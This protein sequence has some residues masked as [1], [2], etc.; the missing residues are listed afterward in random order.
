MRYAYNIGWKFEIIV[1]CTNI[2]L[3]F[4]FV[5]VS[6]ILCK[7]VEFRSFPE[8]LMGQNETLQ[9]QFVR[10]APWEET[11]ARVTS[12]FWQIFSTGG[13]NPYAKKFNPRQIVS[14][15]WRAA[16]KI[17]FSCLQVCNVIINVFSSSIFNF[18]ISY[19]KTSSHLENIHRVS[20][21]FYVQLHFPYLA[22]KYVNRNSIKFFISVCELIRNHLK[23]STYIVHV[24]S[25]SITK[26]LIFV[27]K[28]V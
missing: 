10:T 4:N 21:S 25:H 5:T 8:W 20:I 17:E 6:G 9:G 23:L 15:K 11:A 24:A 13:R 2:S 19:T 22:A 18:M 7:Q 16:F 3:K 12:T 28:T 14:I 27:V 1:V 26:S